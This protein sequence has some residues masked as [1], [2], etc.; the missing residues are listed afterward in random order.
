MTKKTKPKVKPI[1][2]KADVNQLDLNL[3]NAIKADYKANYGMVGKFEKRRFLSYKT[4]VEITAVF[5]SLYYAT[6]PAIFYYVNYSTADVFLAYS[7]AASLF[8]AP[9]AYFKAKDWYW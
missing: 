2:D 6:I 9:I 1:L 4:I 3:V 5:Y 8:V 7:V